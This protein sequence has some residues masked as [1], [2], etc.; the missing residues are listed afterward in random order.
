M[1][2]PRRSAIDMIATTAITIVAILLLVGAAVLARHNLRG[3]RADSTGATRLA[4]AAFGI[5]MTAWIVG[6]QHVSDVQGELNSLTAITA[7]A[8]FV[9]IALW[10]MY[11]AFEP[12]CRRFWPN[13]LLGWT[14]LLSGRVRDSRVGR[15]ILAVSP[16][17]H[18][19]CSSISRGA[20]SLRHSATRLSC[21]GPGAS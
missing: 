13:M 8:A 2:P 1:Q 21:S 17:A 3:G 18:S 19:G 15:D 16:R 6:F 10:I 14:R 9:A 12:Y 7:D 11:A 20:C 5:E 4:I